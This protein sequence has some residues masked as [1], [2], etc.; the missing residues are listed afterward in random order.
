MEIEIIAN[1]LASIDGRTCWFRRKDLWV[2]GEQLVG[3]IG[4]L[5]DDFGLGEN[6]LRRIEI[7]I[8]SL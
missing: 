3:S 4:V 7:R 8:G 5:K 1:G 2:Q 6:Y